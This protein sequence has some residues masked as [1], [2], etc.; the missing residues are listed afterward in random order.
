MWSFRS[1]NAKIHL[2]ED[3]QVEL[4]PH[5]GRSMHIKSLI[6]NKN[7]SM[8]ICLENIDVLSEK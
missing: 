5:P 8:I 1:K 7:F 3:M 6:N 2:T 4:T